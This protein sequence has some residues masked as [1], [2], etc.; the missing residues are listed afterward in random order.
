MIGPLFI[1]PII[2]RTQ[3]CSRCTL[4]YPLREKKCVHCGDLNDQQLVSLLDR[5]EK[6]REGNRQLGSY[7]AIAAAVLFIVLVLM[8]V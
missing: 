4:N 2:R 5:V 8:S 3:K 6:D 1:P 7:F